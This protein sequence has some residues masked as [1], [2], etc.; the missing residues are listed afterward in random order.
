M[1]IGG[2]LNLKSIF[3]VD[4]QCGSNVLFMKEVYLIIFWLTGEDDRINVTHSSENSG[5]GSFL[6][7]KEIFGVL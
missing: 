6:F 1:I 4:I 2:W 5:Y 7:K 3:T